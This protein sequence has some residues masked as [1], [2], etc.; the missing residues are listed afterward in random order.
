MPDDI[1]QL[2]KNSE[3]AWFRARTLHEYSVVRSHV[4][5]YVNLETARVLDF[6]CAAL[7]FAAA[8]FALRHTSAVVYGTDV[9]AIDKAGL[10]SVLREEVSLELPTNLHLETS[11]PSTLPDQLRNLDL[12]YS[13][14]VFEHIRADQL[15]DCFALLGERLSASGVFFLQIDPLYYSSGGSHLSAYFPNEPWHHLTHDLNELQ[16][17]VLG[18]TLPAASNSRHWQ[19]FIELNRL[20]ADDFFDAASD[21]GLQLVWRDQYKRGRTPS[22]FL[23][24]AHTEDALLTTEIRAIYR[25]RQPPP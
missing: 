7:P 19:Q 11:A 25:A 18:S 16:E 20:T 24:R 8:S 12:I 6:G 10:Q 21:A 14:S 23:L 1:D 3:K 15:V 17:L 5:P 13:W 9:V 2:F 22:E 4:L